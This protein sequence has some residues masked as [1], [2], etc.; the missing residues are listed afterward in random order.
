MISFRETT[1]IAG[2]EPTRSGIGVSTTVRIFMRKTDPQAA[3]LHNQELNE[4]IAAD[5][6]KGTPVYRFRLTKGPSKGLAEIRKSG[7]YYYVAF[8][9]GHG[10]AQAGYDIITVQQSYKIPKT[11]GLEKKRLTPGWGI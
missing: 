10:T 5:F 8:V 7:N 11:K 6:A 4:M 9:R 2:I 1:K 3:G